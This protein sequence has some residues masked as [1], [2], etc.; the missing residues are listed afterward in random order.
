MPR[1]L[2]TNTETGAQLGEYRGANP[3]DP[4][5]GRGV[6]RLCGLARSAL[7]VDPNELDVNMSVTGRDGKVVALFS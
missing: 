5:E 1:Y 2:T 6:R 7:N 4:L 3:D